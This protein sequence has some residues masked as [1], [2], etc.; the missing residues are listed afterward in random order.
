MMAAG[1]SVPP[2]PQGW[3]GI[4]HSMLLEVAELLM[5]LWL[6]LE[7]RGE[8]LYTENYVVIQIWFQ[9]NKPKKIKIQQFS[10]NMYVLFL[11]VLYFGLFAVTFV[12]LGGVSF[13]IIISSEQ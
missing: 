7:D 6:P 10:R 2:K 8:V 9:V 1:E 12:V 5:Q 13:P 3:A 11:S 4:S